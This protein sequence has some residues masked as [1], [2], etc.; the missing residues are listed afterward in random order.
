METKTLRLRLELLYESAKSLNHLRDIVSCTI[1]VG[2][3]LVCFEEENNKE[4]NE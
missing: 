2:D 3:V 4:K 1:K